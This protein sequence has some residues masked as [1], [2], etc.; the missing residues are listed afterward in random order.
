[1]GKRQGIIIL[2]VLIAVLLLGNTETYKAYNQGEPVRVGVFDMKGFHSVGEDGKLTGFCID[3]LKVIADVTGW[4]Y[5]FIRVKDFEDGLRLLE[6]KKIDLIAPA[7]MTDARKEEFS[8]SEMYFGMEYSVLLTNHSRT[9][10]YYHD[11]E[12]YNGLKVAVLNGYPMTEYFIDKMQNHGFEM[13]LVYYDSL[14]ECKVALDAGAVDA[15]VTSILYCDD[16]YKVLDVFSP[17]PF[18]FM[19]YKG[20]KELMGQLNNAMIRIEN[21]YPSLLKE[22]LHTYYPVYEAQFFT[23]DELDYIDNEKVLRVAYVSDRKPLSFTDENGELAGISRELFDQI[24]TISG[25]KFEYLA[26]PEGKISYKYLQDQKIDLLTGV[27]YNSTNMNANGIFL[28]RSYV[29]ARKVL[30]SRPEFEY[31]AN[32]NY[33]LAIVEGSKTFGSVIKSKYPNMDI[34]EY[35]TVED[36]FNALYS[37]EVDLLLQNQYVVEWFIGKPMYSSFSV[38]P[39]EGIDDELCFSA[40]MALD[41]GYG[42]GEEEGRIIIEILNKAISQIPDVERDNIVVRSM[43]E[44]QYKLGLSDFIYSYR[45]S[46]VIINIALLLLLVLY[47]VYRREKK[48]ALAIEE[49]EERLKVI[50]QKRYQTIIDCSDDLIYEISVNGDASMGSD[51]IKEKFGWEIPRSSQKLTYETAMEILHIHPEDGEIFRESK[52]LTG[53]SNFDDM[54]LRICK[55]DGTP[56]WCRVSR[57]ILTD[58]HNNPVSILGK[59]V[60]I[61]EEVKEMKSLELRTRTDLLTGLLNKQTF[62]KEVREYVESYSTEC[63]CFVFIDMDH[64]KDINDKFGHSVGDQVIKETAKKIQ[65]LFKNFDLVGRF[66]GDEFCIFVKDIPRDT[67]ID[68]LRFAVKKMEQEY[69]YEG[70]S[71]KLSASIGAA[72]CKRNNVGYRELMDVADAAAYQ[73]KENGRNC[74]II[75]DVE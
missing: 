41:G 57:T 16:S 29:T 58:K 50:Q 42:V 55:V 65:L 61:D 56:V 34:E 30:V 67:L 39:I 53:E 45:Y 13:E 47:M 52:L 43:I 59:I 44:H 32:E 10:L 14:E 35:K 6:N 62:E 38:V 12:N 75:K 64:F 2:F 66:G 68:R 3:Y 4:K 74:Y 22:L 33:S 25:L 71:V 21:T 72:Y 51:K 8:Y 49:Q 24:S 26:L 23:R 17:Q 69:T 73:A 36:C 18:Y 54:T 11:Y 70:G 19:T 27:E 1:M 9:D 37:K 63:A 48:R 28:S 5:E 40:I 15:L 60:D 31:K 46:I 7:M 20:N